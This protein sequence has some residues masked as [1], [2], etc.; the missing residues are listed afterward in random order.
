MSFWMN[1]SSPEAE[2]LCRRKMTMTVNVSI[3]GVR[4]RFAKTLFLA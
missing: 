2:K 3:M 4:F 1:M